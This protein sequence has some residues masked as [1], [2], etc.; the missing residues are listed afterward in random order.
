M[1]ILLTGGNGFIGRNLQT[2]LQDQNLLITSR[3]DIP[4]KPGKYFKKNK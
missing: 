3:H 4:N 1:K 2:K